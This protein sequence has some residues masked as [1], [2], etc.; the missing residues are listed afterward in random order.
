M[1]YSTCTFNPVEDEAVVA[2][3]LLRCGGAMELCDVAECLPGLRR[4]PGKHNWKVRDRNRWEG[5]EGRWE[6][7]GGTRGKPRAEESS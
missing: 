1:V 5:T 2:E 6:G 4:M 7:T 3:L